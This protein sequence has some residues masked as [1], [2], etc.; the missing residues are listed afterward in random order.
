MVDTR[1]KTCLHPGCTLFPCKSASPVN[2]TKTETTATATAKD[3]GT[4]PASAAHPRPDEEDASKA[5]PARFCAAH[6]PEGSANVA[7]RSCRHPACSVQPS[8]GWEGGGGAAAFCA[9][10]RKR[11]MTDVRNPR[12]RATGCVAQPRCGREGDPRPTVC[13]RHAEPDMVNV[14]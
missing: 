13:L 10:H 8:F 2:S 6:A 12:C 4:A 1:H 3:D 11:G 7:V 14:R 5:G 9:R